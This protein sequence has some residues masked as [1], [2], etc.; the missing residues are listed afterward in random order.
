MNL[1]SRAPIDAFS[2]ALVALL[3]AALTLAAAPAAL[4]DAT[5]SQDLAPGA[6][7]STGSTVS[8]QEPLQLTVT[9]PQGGDFTIS[10]AASP[11]QRPQIAGGQG[12][13]DWFGPQFAISPPGAGQQGQ[14][15]TV[16]VTMLADAASLPAPPTFGAN[17]QWRSDPQAV[18]NAVQGGQPDFC[19]RTKADLAQFCWA[20]ASSMSEASCNSSVGSSDQQVKPQLLAD[21]NV[22]ITMQMELTPSGSPWSFDAGYLPWSCSPTGEST[23]VVN[24]PSFDKGTL[25]DLIA[26]GVYYSDGCSQASTVSGEI[27][28]TKQAAR[29]LH[30]NSTVI[31]R[32]SGGPGEGPIDLT[33]AARSALRRVPHFLDVHVALHAKGQLP[34]Q[35]WS[36]SETLRVKRPDQGSGIG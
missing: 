32:L 33:P 3:A 17:P 23:I 10:E 34:G 31:G 2:A 13:M 8:P 19:I 27:T 35:S 15:Q 24:S 36:Y 25:S 11:A 16:T 26:H 9:A 6:S 29:Q 22:Q 30:L 14:D 18:C 7:L 1:K 28:V 5:Y 12:A 4:A 20:A 21:G